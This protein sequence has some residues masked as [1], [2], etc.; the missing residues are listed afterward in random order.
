MV[1]SNEFLSTSSFTWP[2]GPLIDETIECSLLRAIAWLLLL[3]GSSLFGALHMENK[4]FHLCCFRLE[5]E[6]FRSLISWLVLPTQIV[7]DFGLKLEC[8]VAFDL[9]E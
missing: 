5:I 6:I 7:V 3:I 4:A 8:I 2:V 9:L 1:I